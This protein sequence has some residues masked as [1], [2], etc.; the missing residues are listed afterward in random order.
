MEIRES[1]ENYLETI[2]MLS[3]QL[4][5]VRSIDIV[6]RLNFAK[7]SVSV[8]VRHFRE[9]GYAEVDADGHIT[10][11][12]KGLKI[13]Q[14]IYERHEVIASILM[15]LGVDRDTAYEDSCKIEHA[16][17]DKSFQAMKRHYLNS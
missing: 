6:N 9:D 17:S 12:E 10:L 15:S 13:A 3:K 4:E 2:Y 1:A 8:M 16:I 7:P 5:Y 14:K 11:T